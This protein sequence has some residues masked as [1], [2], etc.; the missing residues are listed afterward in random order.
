M[1]DLAKIQDV[2]VQV[3]AVLVFQIFFRTIVELLL[4]TELQNVC[5]PFLPYLT[6]EGARLAPYS[7]SRI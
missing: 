2:N 5:M 6:N 3:S 7:F 1:L 4:M